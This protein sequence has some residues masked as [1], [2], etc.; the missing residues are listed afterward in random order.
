MAVERT[1]N[2]AE[3]I[4][5]KKLAWPQIAIALWLCTLMVLEGYDMQTLSFAAP[6]ILREW[7][8]SRA[9][10][11]F[12]LTAHLVGYFVGA[13]ILS[14]F[15]DRLGKKNIIVAGAMI[16]GVFTFSAGYAASPLELYLLRLGAGFGLG[17]AIPSGIA[18]AAE[19]MPMR[20]RATTIGLM[21]VGYN[22][23]AGLGG[24]IAAWT[25]KD[26]GWSAVFFIGG[27]AAIPMFVGVI[28]S[29]P[30]SVRFLN[31]SGGPPQHLASLVCKSH[32]V[33][34]FS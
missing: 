14:F 28:L 4:E 26:Y 3:R 34:D 16:F 8:V 31:V 27:P 1:L 32:P 29:L 20:L 5:G 18:L 23:G 33:D 21:F 13:M 9:D 7:H 25:I 30:E 10:F 6:A 17:G 11:G 2:V 15:G 12:V 19:F 24:F 22:V